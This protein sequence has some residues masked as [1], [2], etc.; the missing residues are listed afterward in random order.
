MVLSTPQEVLLEVKKKGGRI[1]QER[2]PAEI[3]WGKRAYT[4]PRQKA[5]DIGD[6]NCKIGGKTEYQK[7]SWRDF[8][9]KN[10]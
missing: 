1:V 2:I 4:L 3:G 7:L 5:V 9:E 6:S 10:H 8:G